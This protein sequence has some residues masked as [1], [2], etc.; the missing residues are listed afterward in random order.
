M[1]LLKF[2]KVSFADYKTNQ[3]NYKDPNTKYIIFTPEEGEKIDG[4][5]YKGI[6]EIIDGRVVSNELYKEIGFEMSIVDGSNTTSTD[7]DRY[8]FDKLVLEYDTAKE[9]SVNSKRKIDVY[10]FPAGGGSP[11]MGITLD[12]TGKKIN[13]KSSTQGGGS[14]YR[15]TKVLLMAKIELENL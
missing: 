5:F 4:V 14:G 12:G 7:V 15:T 11:T 10:I 9:M 13:I 6:L 8:G 2:R 1:A 3:A